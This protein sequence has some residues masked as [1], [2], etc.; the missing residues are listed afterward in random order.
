MDLHNNWQHVYMMFSLTNIS[1]L[2]QTY[3]FKLVNSSGITESGESE[4]VLLLME[5]GARF[6]TTQYVRWDATHCPCLMFVL[7]PFSRRL[8]LR[9]SW[10]YA[11]AVIRAPHLRV[12]LWNYE[13]TFVTRGLKMSICLDMTGYCPIPLPSWIAFLVR[14]MYCCWL[15]HLMISFVL[16]VQII[17]FQFGLGSNAHYIIL[18]LYAQ[19]N[20]LL[21]DSE[22]TVMTLLRSHRLV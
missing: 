18:E 13:S 10:L 1:A 3:L 6:H 11:C 15:A 8:I 5:S 16:I 9:P 19:G 17:L 12:S 20:I 14:A 22:Y 4:K 2:G 7:L 21:T